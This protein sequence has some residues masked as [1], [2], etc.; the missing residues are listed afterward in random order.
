MDILPGTGVYAKQY[1]EDGDATILRLPNPTITANPGAHW[2]YGQDWP[3]NEDVTLTVGDYSATVKSSD[4]DK[5]AWF[6]LTG[7]VDLVPGDV[8]TIADGYTTRSLTITELAVTNLDGTSNTIS[9]KASPGAEVTAVPTNT[10][11]GWRF[12]TADENGL[13]SME[14]DPDGFILSAGVSG[15]VAVAD[16]DGNW[17]I[18]DWQLPNPRF[19]LRANV[20]LVEG[21]EWPMGATLTLQVNGDTVQLKKWRAQLHGIQISPMSPL[22]WLAPMTS[23]LETMSA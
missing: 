22:I 3:V 1:D 18:S 5:M 12:A 21:W 20:D 14:P 16:P 13:W 10:S 7:K 4:P 19:D 2:V 9:G 15:Y 23:S 11:G 17:I 6:D 8:V